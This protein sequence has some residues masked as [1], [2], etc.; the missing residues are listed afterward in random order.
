MRFIYLL[1]IVCGFVF[2]DGDGLNT[3]SSTI[4][5][6]DLQ[7]Y[8]DEAKRDAFIEK[9]KEA[10]HKVGFFAVKNTKVNQDIIDDLYITMK[11]FFAF[12]KHNKMKLCADENGNQRGYTSIGKE[13]AKG[14]AIG[15]LKEF[16]TVGR[17]ISKNEAAK[18]QCW[19]NTWPDFMDYKTSAT[20]FYNHLDEYSELFQ[21]IFSLALGEEKDFLFNGCKNGDTILRMLHYPLNKIKQEDKK[22]AVWS[23]AH[24][25]ITL[26]TIL[27]KATAEGLEVCDDQGNWHRVYVKEDAMI[28]NCGDFLEIYTNGYFKSA[29]HRVIQPRNM[30]TDRYSS[31]LFVHPRSECLLYPLQRWVEKTG[32]VPKYIEATRLE[33][34]MERLADL[35][36]AT[37]DML[38]SIADTKLLERLLV[39]N[40]ASK[41]AMEAVY[42]AGYASKEIKRLINQK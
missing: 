28:I 30:Q 20:N 42:K 16:Y 41:E 33:M 39:V 29:L 38:K 5:V 37:D 7:D 14:T 34:L 36:L 35:G 32:G 4:P 6:L 24:T 19:P 22:R 27:P 40:R 13:S 21:E 15:D 10:S 31:V 25:D 26:F 18:L 17:D 11:R 12:E 3:K 23:S 8:F 9:I 1:I 2:A